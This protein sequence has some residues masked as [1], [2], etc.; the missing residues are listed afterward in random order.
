MLGS[1]LYLDVVILG[2]A[3]YLVRKI[4]SKKPEPLPPGP[5]KLPL[6]ENVLDM[7]SSHEWFTFAKWGEKYGTIQLHSM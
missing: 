1:L 4:L 2:F 7:P 6:L 5:S 3:V